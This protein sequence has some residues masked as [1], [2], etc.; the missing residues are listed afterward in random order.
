MQH[1]RLGF[2]KWIIIAA[3]LSLG[4]CGGDDEAA[5]AAGAPGRTTIGGSPP[6]SAVV[7][8]EYSFTPAATHAS[9]GTLTFS[10]ANLPSWATFSAATGRLE[11]TPTAA[12]VGTFANIAI[13]VSDG[14]ERAQLAPF[15][16]VVGDASNRAPTISGAPPAA[17]TPGMA[18][19]FTP[20]S[21]DPDGDSPTFSIANRP[22]WATFD[23]A[24]GRLSGTP[25]IGDIGTTSGIV[26]SVTDGG[27]S[28]SLPAFDLTVQAMASGSATLSWTP[29]TTNTDGSPL[30]NL[31][32]YKVYW[33]TAPG[34]YPNFVTLTNPGLTTYVVGNLVPGTYFFVATALNRLGTES[35]FSN[36]AS[37]TV[38]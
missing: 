25:G 27:A 28:A 13:S 5:T 3:C 17:V 19:R 10:I 23:A 37:K 6:T 33:G 15:S 16:I 34:D 8:A 4:A 35:T 21:H 14:R 24:T 20:A 1:A 22:A 11:G 18:Y 31:A 30:T 26:I 7:G 36:P 38:M 12:N 2:R 32:G 9:G 29:P